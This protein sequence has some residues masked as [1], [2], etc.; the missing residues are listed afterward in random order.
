[1]DR[2]RENGPMMQPKI[3]KSLVPIPPGADQNQNPNGPK[4]PS[5]KDFKAE[6]V[7]SLNSNIMKETL[8][9]SPALANAI[10]K[11]SWKKSDQEMMALLDGR[12]LEKEEVRKIRLA[13]QQAT[14]RFNAGGVDGETGK[15]L[16]KIFNAKLAANSSLM[17]STGTITSTKFM[18]WQKSKLIRIASLLGFE[19]GIILKI[20]RPRLHQQPRILS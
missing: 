12:E 6:I 14:V 20:R 11:T 4:K 19:F 8:A 1:M 15:E 17:T 2:P 13:E 5:A 3:T 9:Q 18:D 16:K 10:V 7:R